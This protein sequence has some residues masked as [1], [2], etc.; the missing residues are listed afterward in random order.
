M[1]SKPIRLAVIIG[2]TRKARLGPMVADWFVER[3]RAHGGVEI[4]VVDLADAALPYGLDGQ[5]DDGSYTSPAVA[6]YAARIDAADAFVVVTPEYNRGYP[7]ALKLAI[8][9]VYREW[10]AKPVGF[11]SHGGQSGGLRAVEQLRQVFAELHAVTMRDGVCFPMAA[12]Q[13]EDGGSPRDAEG[14]TIS[15]KLLLDQLT[16]WAETLRT[17]R[18]ER[19]YPC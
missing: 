19:P 8:D 10:N 15:A 7:A 12:Q 17:A 3:A 14:A 9:T 2:S 18:A 6:A 16:W 4:D 13:F 1:S 5:A 11:V